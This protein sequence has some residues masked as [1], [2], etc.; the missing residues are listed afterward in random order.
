MLFLEGSHKLELRTEPAGE[1]VGVISL[2][3][4][5]AAPIGTPGTEG[6]Y[7]DVSPNPQSRSNRVQVR[8]SISLFRQEMKHSPVVPYVDLSR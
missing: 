4:Q 7:D 6:R 3:L 2:H 1:L 8:L 5:T